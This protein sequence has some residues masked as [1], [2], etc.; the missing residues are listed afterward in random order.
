MDPFLPVRA[1]CSQPPWLGQDLRGKTVL[2]RAE[3]GFGDTIQFVRFAP[4]LQALG[5]KVV[6]RGQPELESLAQEGFQGIDRILKRNEPTP[7]F[8]F[9]VHPLS[10]AHA[11][12]IDLESLPAANIP[13]VSPDP[14][15]VQHWA[16]RLAGTEGLKIGVVWAGRPEHPRDRQRSVPLRFLAEVCRVEGVQVFSLQKGPAAGEIRALPRDLNIV[17][18]GAE[19]EDFSDTAALIAQLDL[20]ICVDTAVAHLAGALAKPVWLLLPTPAD[21]RW[22]EG[23]DDSPWYP[24]MRLFRQTQ[25]NEWRGVIDRVKNALVELRNS[26]MMPFATVPVHKSSAEQRSKRGAFGNHPVRAGF[27]AAVETRDGILQF[28]PDEPEIGQSLEHYGEYL[29][30]QLDQLARLIRLGQVVIEVGAGVGAHSLMLSRAVGSEGHLFLYESRPLV[31]RILRQNIAANRI[32]NATIMKRS[33]RASSE[34]EAAIDGQ[35]GAAASNEIAAFTTE[36]VDE[37]RLTRLDWLKINAG[38]SGVAVLDGATDTLWRLRPVLMVGVA[39]SGELSNIKAR[40]EEASYRCWRMETPLFN[41]ANFNQRNDD[42]F[43]GKVASTL[44]AIPEEIDVDMAFEGCV[45]LS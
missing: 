18:L 26:S 28:L 21:W 6:L 15:K 4:K 17:D 8:D 33:L 9:Y 34:R 19:L 20:V 11:F 37:L 24:S 30:I 36:T 44:I 5:A 38:V 10:L 42:V 35:A 41:S 2:L 43:A 22:L 31:Q 7:D 23:R 3:Q 25:R 32:V 16:R 1:A 13:Y 14:M 39:D 29:Q 12:N 40:V 27:T 45:E